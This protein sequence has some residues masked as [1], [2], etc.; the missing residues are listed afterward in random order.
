MSCCPCFRL[1]TH[2]RRLSVS[3]LL[4]LVAAATTES[5]SQIRPD[6]A[7]AQLRTAVAASSETELQRVEN[8]FPGTEEAALARLLR[9]YQRLQAKD[10]GTAASLLADPLIARHSLLDDYALF[11][12]AQALVGAG[13]SEEAESE[14]LRLAQTHPSVLLARQARRKAAESA[15]GRGA[16]QVAINLLSP[17]VAEDD[18]NALSL[19]ADALGKLGR[20][21]EAVS[22]LRRLYFSAPQ[23]PEATAVEQRLSALGSS[24]APATALEQR[25][26]GDRLYD[27]GLF[28]LAAQSYDLLAR[29]FPSA[30]TNEVWLRAGI[31]NYRISSAGA[32][33]DAL[34][35]VRARTPKEQSEA[36]Y[37]TASSQIA[38]RRVD[39]AL[40]TLADLRRAAPD[41]QRVADL[42]YDLGRSADRAEQTSQAASYYE[43]LVKQFPRD[44]RADDAHFWLGWRAH[45]AKDYSQSSQR[46]LEHLADYGLQTDNRGKAAFWAAVDAERAGAKSQALTLYR[47]LLK[48]YS[49]CRYGLNAERRIAQLERSGVKGQSPEPGSALDRAIKALQAITISPETLN[50][51]ELVRVHKAEQLMQLALWQPAMDELQALREA[52]PNSPLLCLR[53]AEVLRGRTVSAAAINTLRRAYPDYSQTLPEEMNRELWEVFYPLN[54]WPTIQQESRRHNIDPYLVAGIIR[55]ETIFNPQARSRANALGLMQLLPSTGQLV[56]RKYSLGGGRITSADL[57][58][59]ILNIQLGTAYLSDLIAEFGRFDYAAA[60]YNGGPTRTARWLR[61]LPTAE[62]EEWVDSIPL[63][64]TRNYVQGVRRNARQYQRLYDEQGRFR[65]IVPER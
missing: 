45:Q 42:I 15:V 40:Q 3:L 37:Y 57:F 2:H 34:A 50:S 63:S 36:L 11:Y 1:E 20:T 25:A 41:S 22:T 61:E 60:A 32:A 56:A 46:L 58:N 47:A 28:V 21:D 12:R 5:V 39:A 14:Y 16:F 18:G 8:S 10:Y 49:A 17:L 64:E 53:I 9:G 13:R 52:A 26:R 48:R 35:R 30:A 27:A 6:R 4:L 62:I 38:L 51:A 55:Q 29:Q 44:E 7:V 59:P 24:T 23:S 43:Q 54:W 33:I 31:S 19:K 65:S